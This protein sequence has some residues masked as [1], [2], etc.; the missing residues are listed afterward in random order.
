M[1]GKYSK[2][3]AAYYKKNRDKILAYKKEYRKSNMHVIQKNRQERYSAFIRFKENGCAICGY[4]K[5][6]AALD[7]HH[8]EPSLKKFRISMDTINKKN[9]VEELVKCILVC[10]NC[11]YELHNLE[12]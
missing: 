11:H 6:A 10:K 3:N 4:T 12:E 8:V 7:F 9:F 1:Q 5:C 2:T